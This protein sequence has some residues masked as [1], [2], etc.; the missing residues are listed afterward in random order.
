MVTVRFGGDGVEVD[1]AGGGLD[2]SRQLRLTV[3]ERA[4]LCHGTVL[5]PPGG[6]RVPRLLVRLP[7]S[8]PE[9]LPA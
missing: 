5:P 1:I 7:F 8:V 3:N 4:E 6:D 2:L 9:V